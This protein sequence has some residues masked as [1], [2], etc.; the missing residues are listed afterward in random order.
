MVSH[1]FLMCFEALDAHRRY[2]DFKTGN[3]RSKWYFVAPQGWYMP[4][5]GTAYGGELQF[6]VKSTYGD[7]HYLNSPLDWVR[8]RRKCVAGGIHLL[9]GSWDTCVG[10]RDRQSV[11]WTKFL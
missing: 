9:L 5:I 11:S 6:T 7:F 1:A 4:D 10:T 3:D 2:V 8:L